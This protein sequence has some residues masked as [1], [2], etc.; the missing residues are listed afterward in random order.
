MHIVFSKNQYEYV[1]PAKVDWSFPF[2]NNHMYHAEEAMKWGQIW[3]VVKYDHN[4]GTLRLFVT[5]LLVNSITI[6]DINQ[7]D[8]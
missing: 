7:N 1:C 3:P 8:A 2:S 5:S 4:Y 6:L